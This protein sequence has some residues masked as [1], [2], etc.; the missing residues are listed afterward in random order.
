M[1]TQV[2]CSHAILFNHILV[3]SCFT[4]FDRKCYESILKN[5]F[6]GWPLEIVSKFMQHL[7]AQLL[8]E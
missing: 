5:I 7:N 8:E 4:A 1:L 6:K 2:Q 3:L